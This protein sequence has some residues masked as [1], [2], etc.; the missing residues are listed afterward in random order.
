MIF[1]Q[2][3]RRGPRARGRAQGCGAAVCAYTYVKHT[4]NI[5]R[6]YACLFEALRRMLGRSTS[7]DPNPTPTPDPKLAAGVSVIFH[8]MSRCGPRAR[9][10]GEVRARALASVHN[11]VK[12]D[13][14]T[15]YMPVPC[16]TDTRWGGPLA[17]S[18]TGVN[19]EA[20]Q[21]PLGR[22]RCGKNALA[23]LGML[24]FTDTPSHQPFVALPL[25]PH[26][27]LGLQSCTYT[28]H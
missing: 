15:H 4:S 17:G 3:S 8:Q 12:Y 21:H 28:W 1:H 26:S 24:I 27:S 2:T 7:P 16:F 22:G 9:G 19:Q 14:T 5:Q 23:A 20:L 10:M 6:L 18:P 25:P 11:A 13:I